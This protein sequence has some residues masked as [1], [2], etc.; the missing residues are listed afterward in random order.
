MVMRMRPGKQAGSFV[1]CHGHGLYMPAA[2]HRLRPGR[3]AYALPSPFP[4]TLRRRKAA[5]PGDPGSENPE[6]TITEQR[7]VGFDATEILRALTVVPQAAK[8]LGASSNTVRGVEFLPD[9]AAVLFTRSGDTTDTTV[10]AAEAL[11]ALLV[12]YCVTIRL[13]LPHA[14]KKQIVVEAD[15]VT[16]HIEVATN[17]HAGAAAWPKRFPR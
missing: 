16:L 6:L 2:P 1:R 12:A 5:L 13:P 11:A 9:K 14:G 8:L 3:R 17:H 10:V 7:T 4:A 15:Q